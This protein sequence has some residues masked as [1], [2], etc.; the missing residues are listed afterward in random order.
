ER[1][2]GS[3]CA[4]TTALM[5]RASNRLR[6]GVRALTTRGAQGLPHPR[7]DRLARSTDSRDEYRDLRGRRR[8]LVGRSLFDQRGFTLIELLVVIIVLGLLVGLVGPRLFG[9][10]GQ[11]KQAAARAQ[12]ELL[13]AALD[14]YRLDIGSYPNSGQGLDALQ[15]NPNVNNWNGPY[16][17]KAVPKD[18]WGNQYKYRCCP[19]QNGEYDLWSEGADGAPGGEGE[20]ADITSWDSSQK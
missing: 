12:I 14:Q 8:S 19:G 13:G 1:G 9:R 3:P 7:S 17:K 11:S 5:H 6:S 16:L 10:V 20:N 18:P 4:S 15:R 2:R